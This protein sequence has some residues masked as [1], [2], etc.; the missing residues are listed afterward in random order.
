MSESERQ[1]SDPVPDPRLLIDA[2]FERLLS[3]LKGFNAAHTEAVRQ[4]RNT[5][6]TATVLQSITAGINNLAD[7]SAKLQRTIAAE[8]PPAP[9][10]AKSPGA[11]PRQP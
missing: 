2:A 4:G 6:D 10:A 3:A 7:L 8:R 11:P 9:A 1:P 5:S